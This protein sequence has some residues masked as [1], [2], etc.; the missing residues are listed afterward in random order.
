MKTALLVIDVQ[1][2][3]FS[4]SGGVYEGEEVL[5]NIKEAIDKA[6]E[7]E[8]PVIYIQH[9][10]DSHFKEG[11][12]GWQI[13]SFIAPQAGELVIKKTK[14]DSFYKTSLKETLDKLGIEQLVICGMQTEFCVDTTCR[15]AFSHGYKNILIRNG[16]TT[17][18]SASFKAFNIIIHHNGIM[19]GR[20]AELK[21]AAE[22]DFNV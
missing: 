1:N 20:F 15:A 4:Y 18:D 17:F 12:E 16:H 10:D 2:I 13:H 5:K 3:M 19:N 21:T 6:R 9:C 14:N 8:V 22:L 7:A 11:T